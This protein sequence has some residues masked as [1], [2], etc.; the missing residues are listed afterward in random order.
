[1]AENAYVCEN[2]GGIMVF[3]AQTQ[4]LKC[5]NCDTVAQIN[6]RVDGIVEH[7][8]D[9]RIAAT[10]RTKEK[11]SSTMECSGCGATIE[12]DKDSTATICPYCGSKYV[13]AQKQEEA[14]LPDGVIP[15]QIDNNKVREIF[16]KWINGLKMAPGE[17]KALYQQGNIQG[18]YVPFWTF[19]AD[20]VARYTGMGG[21]D[22]IEHYKDKDGNDRTRTVTDWYPTSGTIRHFFDDVLVN[23]TSN[24]K[25]S[26]INGMDDYDLKQAKPYSPDYFSG[27][28]AES[29]SIDMETAHSSARRQME[30]ALHSMADSEIRR[31]YD[32]SKDVNVSVSYSG[33]TYKHMMLPLYATSYSYKNK[34]YTVLVNGQNGKIK[35]EY[36]KSPFKIALIVIAIIIALA[37]LWFASQDSAG[38]GVS[39]EPFAVVEKQVASVYGDIWENV[40]SN[41]SMSHLVYNENVEKSEY[42]INSEEEQW[43]YLAINL[44]M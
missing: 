21:K 39:R 10:Y 4:T 2:C 18:R 14:I 42:V 25:A 7:P 26:L 36:P 34:N 24:M 38:D 17:L 23:G 12:V 43:D 20:T 33:E 19:D 41:D 31:K 3:D 1:M 28:L 40:V 44:P 5:P 35:G 32:R 37:A 13:L 29:Y 27:F 6:V 9:R 15:F 8:Y 30:S 11:T 22:R 16:G